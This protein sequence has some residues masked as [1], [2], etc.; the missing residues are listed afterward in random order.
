MQRLRTVHRLW[1]IE[2]ANRWFRP[3]ITVTPRFILVHAYRTGAMLLRLYVRAPAQPRAPA[4]R[5]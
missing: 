4:T 1:V 3:L 2:M 5:R